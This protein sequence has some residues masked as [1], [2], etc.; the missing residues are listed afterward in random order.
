MAMAVDKGKGVS[1]PIPTQPSVMAT[2]ADD[3][4]SMSPMDGFTFE[5]LMAA[6]A[7]AA[8]P[9]TEHTDYFESLALTGSS[10]PTVNIPGAGKGKA[11]A[12]GPPVLPPLAFTPMEI[13]YGRVAWPSPGSPSIAGPSGAAYGA[14]LA[15][16]VDAAP[17]AALVPSRPAPLRTRSLSSASVLSTRSLASRIR[18]KLGAPRHS[19]IL[20]RKT[21]AK[22][23]PPVAIPRAV[24]GLPPT[25]LAHAPRGSL[26][27][28]ESGL[29]PSLLPSRGAL[30]LKNAGRAYT[31]P[32]PLTSAVLE[33][34]PP[35]SADLALPVPVCLFEERLPSEVKL[36]VMAKIVQLH[37][38]AHAK[39]VREGAWTAIT[40]TASSNRWVG[41]DSGMRELIRL[42][43]VGGL[44]ECLG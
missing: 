7:P 36:L 31:S 14:I 16:I 3:L 12:T 34:V 10:T 5:D 20:N 35:S 25:T 40:A 2:E 28:L 33:V 37:E 43:Q 29:P 13:K 11:R 30:L 44:F 38:E 21:R 39:T 17:T 32:Y 6:P 4:F 27:D 24:D 26:D 8:S 19:N 18:V 1:R 42:G 41:T 9:S 15:S 23:A 22:P